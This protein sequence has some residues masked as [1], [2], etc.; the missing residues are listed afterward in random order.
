MVSKMKNKLKLD[1]NLAVENYI[2]AF[3]KKHGIDFEFWISD[4]VGSVCNI[5]DY[6]FDFQDI[7]T[8][9]DLNVSTKENESIFAWQT[10]VLEAQEKKAKYQIN[11]KSWLK[12]VR[13]ENRI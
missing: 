6:F 13:N 3:C 12:G 1:Y 4:E 8:D 7:K 10:Y 5:G 2:K 9:I 11:F